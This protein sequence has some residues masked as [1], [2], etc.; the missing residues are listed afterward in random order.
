MIDTHKNLCSECGKKLN[1]NNK[2]GYCSV[3]R[4]KSRDHIDTVIKRQRE[5][6]KE[7]SAYDKKHYQKTKEKRKEQH[8]VWLANNPEYTKSSNQK[9]RSSEL[10][11]LIYKVTLTLC[12][13]F[14]RKYKKCWLYSYIGV[15]SFEDLKEKI[16]D[17]PPG[18]S[19]DHVCPMSK[20]ANINEIL[21]LQHWSNLQF[22]SLNDNISKGNRKTPEGERL[23]KQ[24]LNRDWDD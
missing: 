17:K 2:S 3:C 22:L 24:L 20:A 13:I 1:K 5:N 9:R 11:A 19:L 15:N 8:K 10:G 18:M 21:V 23:C 6:K 7:K 12:D 14:R 16:G 4:D